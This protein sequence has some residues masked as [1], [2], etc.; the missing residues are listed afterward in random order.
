MEGDPGAQPVEEL[1]ASF[2]KPARL[3]LAVT[4]RS[5]PVLHAFHRA[6]PH[7]RVKRVTSVTRS[8]RD[9]HT[10]VWCGHIM[11]LCVVIWYSP[12]NGGRVLTVW[13]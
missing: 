6:L 5:S 3:W 2:R 9:L 7:F 11:C 12:I 8:L 1:A 4:R 10:L 13:R